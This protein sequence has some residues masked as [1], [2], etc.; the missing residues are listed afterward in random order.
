M[1]NNLHELSRE[2]KI[3][4]ALQYAEQAKTDPIVFI[5]RFL[6]TYDPKSPPFHLPFHLFDFQKPLVMEIKQAIDEGYDIFIEKTREM[7]ATYTVLDVLLWFWRYIPGCNFLLGSRKEDYVD[8]RG[9]GAK[10]ELTNKEESLFGKLDYTITRMP[11]MLLPKDFN[12][13]IHNTYMSLINP[14]NGNVIAGESSNPNFSRGSRRTAVLYDEFAFWE[15]D[16]E[17]WSAGADTTRCR[18]VLTTPGIKPS[19]AKRLRF[20]K[21]GE[22]IKV[23]TLPHYLDPRKTPEWLEYERSRRSPEDFAR[24]IMI[25]WDKSIGGVIYTE[26]DKEIHVKEFDHTKDQYGDYFFGMDF[27]VRGWTANVIGY[28]GSDGVL[29]ILDEYKVQGK[30]ALVHA[31]EIV[32][33]AE[34]YASFDKYVGYGD[35]AGFA[36]N[37]Q[38]IKN[39]KEMIWSLADEYKEYGFPLVAG[40]NEVTA[41]INFVK[42]QFHTKKIIIHKRCEKLIEE[43]LEYRWKDQPENRREE[44]DEPEKVRKINDHLVD[45]LRYM[46]YSK[47]SAPEEEEQPRTTVF[48]ALFPIKLEVPSEENDEIAPLEIPSA[49]D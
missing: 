26:F 9:A 15:F 4:I 36:K 48:P 29:K 6:Y 23:I 37:Q 22:R 25:N 2:E 28:M 39:G 44:E 20:G 47:P 27:G 41:G 12:N 17:A 21:D 49:F 1:M 30:I 19:K 16:D 32:T 46:L 24:E 40:N 38:G 33:I 8:N 18:I 3:K 11:Q 14:D 13:R 31:P 35:P 34:K 42:Q 45:A 7:G 5:D 43:L 10:S